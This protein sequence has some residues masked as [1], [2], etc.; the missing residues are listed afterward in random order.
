MKCVKD[1]SVKSF[2]CNKKC[3]GFLVTSFNKN[4][5]KNHELNN[6]ITKLADYLSI[7]SSYLY[8]M[9]NDLEDYGDI[10]NFIFH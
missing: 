6:F 4:E 2:S 10:L 3:S 8:S 5:I 7:Q 9:P 1:I